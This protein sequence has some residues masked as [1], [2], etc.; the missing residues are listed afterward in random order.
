M[1]LPNLFQAPWEKLHKNYMGAGERWSLYKVL[2]SISH[3][4]I[5]ALGIPYDW[6]IVTVNF[7]TYITH[8]T[9]HTQ[10]LT[11]MLS[12]WNPPTPHLLILILTFDIL[13]SETVFQEVERI[14]GGP[15]Y[16]KRF[17]QAL[18]FFLPTIFHSFAISLLAHFFAYLHRPR[19]WHRLALN[20]CSKLTGTQL[21]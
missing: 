18:P 6:P 8:L 9:L 7:F 20:L 13:I 1:Q 2:F 15:M 3:S 12:K 16:L 10:S 11:N 4:R 17:L 14:V 19:G 21:K 5:L